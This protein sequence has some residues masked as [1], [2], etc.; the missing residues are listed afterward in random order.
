[1]RFVALHF[2]NDNYCI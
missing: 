1:M 2:T